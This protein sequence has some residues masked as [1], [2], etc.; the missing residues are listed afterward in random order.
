[1]LVV[2]DGSFAVELGE[3]DDTVDEDEVDNEV[4]KA[5]ASGAIGVE[6]GI[7]KTVMVE[8]AT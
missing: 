2:R 1:M 3:S 4:H 7:G 6:T 8:T 5:D